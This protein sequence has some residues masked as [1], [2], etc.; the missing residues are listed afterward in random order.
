MTL[1][2]QTRALLL[3]ASLSGCAHSRPERA[4]TPVEAVVWP[5]P[6]AAPRVRLA[7][8]LPDPRAPRPARPW[9]RTVLDWVTG[10][11]TDDEGP[12]LPRPFG[13]ASGSDGSIWVA[14]PDGGRVVRFDPRGTPTLV[15]CPGLPWDAPMAL[16]VGSDGA[17]Y[18][19]DAAAGV[20]VRWTPGGC[21]ALGAGLLER[22][23]GVAAAAAGV[24]VAD[25]PR[26]QV[27]ALDLRGAVVARVGRHGE[28]EGAF[29]FPSAVAA[30]P[31]G[32]IAVVD[33]LN[34]RVVLL[35]SDG[36]WL[37][38]FGERG[39]DGGQFSL[40]KAIAASSNGSLFVTDAQR[41]RVLVFGPDGV[42][43]HPIGE[44]GASPG[45]FTHPAGV[46]LSGRRLAV[47][48][49]YNHRVQLFELLGGTP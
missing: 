49:S 2:T 9:W 1:R 37:G 19:A 35:S 45:Q 34:F 4:A 31:D 22:P 15:T 13:L 42:F 27:V 21:T 23:T 43:D 40:P 24:W 17:V 8:V 48:D 3:L 12:L 30:L 33:S 11:A 7:Q 32:R 28:G 6:P 16:S 44:T 18:V 41:D 10:G 5:A 25:P 26:H 20:V 38:S 39:D 29:N 36:R 46:A 14:D 47:A